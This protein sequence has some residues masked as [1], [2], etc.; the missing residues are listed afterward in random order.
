[1]DKEFVDYLDKKFDSVNKQFVNID[2]K[3]DNVDKQF[4]NIDKKFDN[5]NKQ[6]VNID[7]KFDNVNKQFVNIDKKFD[8]VDKQIK[9]KFDKV[10]SGQDK[11]FK[12]LGDLKQESIVS[13]ELYKKHDEKIED[14]SERILALEIKS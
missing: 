5:V 12:E 10:L 11:I 4:V 14:Y 7:K 9:N 8:N 1:M 6:F 2:K 13:T 3:F